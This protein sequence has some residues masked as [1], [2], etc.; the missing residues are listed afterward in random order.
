MAAKQ[1]S[2]GCI[3]CVLILGIFVVPLVAIGLGMESGDALGIGFVAF[4]LLWGH[5]LINYN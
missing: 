5:V 3:G 1:S 2:D 4:L